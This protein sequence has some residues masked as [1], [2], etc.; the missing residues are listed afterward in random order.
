MVVKNL[1]AMQDTWV[2][3]LHQ[4]DPLN[5]EMAP[6]G[7]FPGEIDGLRVL[8]G[9]SPWGHKESDTTKQLTLYFFFLLFI[10]SLQR[11][12]GGVK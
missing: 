3:S 6:P 9:Y 8:V 11:K 1:P 4:E 7:F 12:N 2:R 5:K 10:Y